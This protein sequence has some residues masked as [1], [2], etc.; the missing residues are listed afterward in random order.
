M[1]C[2]GEYTRLFLRNPLHPCIYCIMS[3]GGGLFVS[4][5]PHVHLH[6]R[7]SMS[8]NG[9]VFV[10][11]KSMVVAFMQAFKINPVRA[12]G[13]V[14]TTVCSVSLSVYLI[15]ISPWY[16]LPLA[17]AFAGTA[18]TGV[19]LHPSLPSYPTGFVSLHAHNST[20]FLVCQL[21]RKYSRLLHMGTL[22]PHQMT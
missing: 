20:H 5:P 8:C 9:L 22:D 17:W 18:W 2:C 10:P 1:G 14:L 7:K 6:E 13:A 12:W 21:S 11:Q 16:M 4:I 15:S 19:C 3:S